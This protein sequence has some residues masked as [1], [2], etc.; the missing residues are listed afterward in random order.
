MAA[1]TYLLFISPLLFSKIWIAFKVN[2][3]L[4]DLEAL[5]HKILQYYLVSFKCLQPMHELF[6]LNTPT[7]PALDSSSY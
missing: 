4:C 1:S 3:F 2:K 6:I 7:F 5:Y